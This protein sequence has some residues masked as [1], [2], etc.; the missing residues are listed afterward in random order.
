MVLVRARLAV[1]IDGCFWHACPVHFVPPKAN[2]E[3]WAAKLA[4]TGARDRRADEAL[5]AMGWEPMHVWEHEDID[6][7]ADVIAARWSA[8]SG[9]R[10]IS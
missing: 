5:A 4:A 7:V 2:A 9:G 1:F 8:A 10:V 6:T 3:W